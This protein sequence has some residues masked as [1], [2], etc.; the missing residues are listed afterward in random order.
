MAAANLSLSADPA[1]S[2]RQGFTI[3]DLSESIDNGFQIAMQQGPMCAEP[4]QGM[5]YFVEKIE[6]DSDEAAKDGGEHSTRLDRAPSPVC[7]F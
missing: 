3:S 7:I 4:V 5:A 1:S 6:V 2:K